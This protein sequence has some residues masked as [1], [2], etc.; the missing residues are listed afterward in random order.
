MLT[1]TV[2]K[3][4]NERFP[5]INAVDYSEWDEQEE[6]RG[7]WLRNGDEYLDRTPWGN[8]ES[9]EGEVYEFLQL[10][11]WFLEPHDN[12]TMMAWEG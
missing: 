7:I 6:G 2:I 12:E 8:L 4:L 3:K 10:L 5:N 9:M 1:K 11:G